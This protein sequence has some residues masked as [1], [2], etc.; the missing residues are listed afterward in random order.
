MDINENYI[1]LDLASGQI[2]NSWWTVQRHIVI[3]GVHLQ[4]ACS[5][6]R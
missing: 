4:A 1:Y 6:T 2:L 5:R 3:S